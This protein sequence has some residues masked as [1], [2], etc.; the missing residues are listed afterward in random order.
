M[1]NLIVSFLQKNYKISKDLQ[2]F[3]YYE[4]QFLPFYDLVIQPLVE[5]MEHLDWGKC[6]TNYLP[7]LQKIAK[8]ILHMLEAESVFDVTMADL[9][10]RNEGYINL[11]ETCKTATNTI[12]KDYDRIYSSSLEQINQVRQQS[13]SQVSGL[14]F[15]VMTNNLPS[16]LLYSAMGVSTTK[17]QMRQAEKYYR[18]A[19]DNIRKN[20]ESQL[21]QS[22]QDILRAYYYPTVRKDLLNFVD[23]AFI[24]Y[25]IALEDHGHICRKNITQYDTCRSNEL[26]SNLDIVDNKERM[27][28]EAYKASPINLSVYLS[29]IQQ[30]FDV[31]SIIES[32]KAFYLDK[33]LEENLYQICIDNFTNP[34][35]IQNQ[36]KAVSQIRGC[37]KEIVWEEIEKDVKKIRQEEKEQERIK[38]EEKREL[39]RQKRREQQKKEDREKIKKI[40]I[41]KFPRISLYMFFLGLFG[42]VI[43]IIDDNSTMGIL[44]AINL[45][46]FFFFYYLY[47]N[48]KKTYETYQELMKRAKDDD[49]LKVPF[50]KAPV[51]SLI[52]ASIIPSIIF[53]LLILSI[54]L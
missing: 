31:S 1:E 19:V 25:L 3:A 2:K 5:Q 23:K 11:C 26:L 27:I 53:L 8:E 29:A 50:M 36:V 39:E 18:D 21:Q 24:R 4:K 28:E 13:D 6:E 9:V 46:W 7:H 17:K 48:Y 40:E 35:A 30:G 51:K 33:S 20:R 43:S 41:T 44:S 10:E 42:I 45:I 38:Q 47:N 14:G 22:K 37:S 49:T 16:A 54:I 32:A 34:Q 15:G 12:S 52:S